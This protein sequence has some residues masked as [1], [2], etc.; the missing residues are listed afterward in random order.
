VLAETVAAL[1]TNGVQSIGRVCVA[2]FSGGYVAVR[3]ILRQPEL[4][5]RISDVVL[6][7]SLYAPKVPG[8]TNELE[9]EAMAPFLDY[10]WN[11]AEGKG[12]FWFSQLYP[13]EEKY[14]DNTTTLAAYYLTDHLQVER[15][16]AKGWNAAGATLLYRADK[17]NFHVLGYAGMLNQDHFNHFYGISDLFRETS[18]ERVPMP[19]PATFK[20]TE[21]TW[22]E[23]K[24][25]LPNNAIVL[26]DAR[27][28][29]YYRVG[30]IP[31][32]VA[33]P[34]A[35]FNTSIAAFEA[36]Y[37]RNTPLVVYCTSPSCEQAHWEAEALIGAHGFNNV[38]LMPGG[39]EEYTSVEKNAGERD[40]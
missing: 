23:V 12:H 25:L 4:T 8:K 19:D 2:S 24:A 34:L 17:G 20:F 26:V 15:R 33:L 18:L 6:A 40:K 30:R 1:K 37:P 9:P 31:G 16:A 27:P 13:P 39:Y 32:A 3:S 10:A 21:L 36:T 28:M 11:A 5:A 7:D 38:R 22:S 29:E 35:Q 14:R